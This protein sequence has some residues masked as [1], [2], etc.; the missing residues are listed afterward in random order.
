MDYY[1]PMTD[2]ELSQFKL[3]EYTA[4]SEIT[5]WGRKNPAR[6]AE[7]MFGTQLMDFQRYIIMESWDKP[8]VLW[9]CSRGAS[10]TT[11]A[12]IYYMTKL[13]LIPDYTVY[14]STLTAGQSIEVFSKLE[15]LALQRDPHFR[16]LTD[17]FA[18]EIERTAN[19]DTGFLHNPATG[20]TFR[21]FNNSSYTTL[22]SNINALRG[23]RGSVFFDETAWMMAEQLTVVENFINV[24]NSFSTSTEKNQLINPVNMPLQTLYA[25][26]AGDIEFPFYDKY[27]LFSKKMISGD[28]NY[29]VCD[30]NVNDV[31]YNSTVNGEPIKSHITKSQ[32]DKQ[33]RDEPE[34]AQRELFNKF[35]KGGGD[36]SVLSMDTVIRNSTSRPPLLY[37]DTGKKKFVFCYDPARAYDNSILSIFQVIN[38]DEVGYKLR[39]ENIVSM[40]DTESEKKTPLPFNKQLDVIKNLMIRY[41]GHRAAEWENI[42][43]YIDAGSGG[44]GVSGIADALM[45]AWEDKNGKMHRGIIDPDHKQYE[46]SRTKYK[47]AASIVHLLEPKTHKIHMFD[48]L[49][50]MT[51]LNLIDFPITDVKD[52]ILIPTKTDFTEYNLNWEEKLS[53]RQCS[54]MIDETICIVRMD[55]GSGTIRY[56]LSRDKKNIMHDDRAYTLAMAAYALSLMR[57]DELISKPKIAYASDQIKFSFRTPKIRS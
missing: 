4:F 22:S 31:L 21:L 20:Y 46:T 53:L 40:V 19:S 51:K 13:M 54:L 56:D 1:I 41:N 32:V 35:R 9:L 28:S 27:R 11:M 14:V 39:L 37:N 23:K 16:S 8:F 3:D 55:T 45:D 24:D 44:G 26:S 25:S 47:T 34:R 49:E 29:F 33:M 6:F 2:R 38:D 43:F 15:N 12:A 7:R 18:R 36:D 10:K 5:A 42:E 30:L 57:R 17:I 52:T 50:K 48:A